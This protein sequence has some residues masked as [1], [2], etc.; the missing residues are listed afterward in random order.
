LLFVGNHRAEKGLDL[1]TA[2]AATTGHSLRCIGG[3]DLPLSEDELAAAYATCDLVVCPYRDEYAASGSASLVVA[4]ALA[5]AAPVLATSAL[6]DLFP[7]G[8]TAVEF[9]TGERRCVGRCIAVTRP[10]GPDQ[11]NAEALTAA[12]FVSPRLRFALLVLA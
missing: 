12:A 1:V 5:Y 9:A 10:R 8:Y 4:E 3:D 2:A 6:R 7:A 11:V